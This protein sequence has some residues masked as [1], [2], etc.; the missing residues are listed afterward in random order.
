MPGPRGCHNL[1]MPAHDCTV[2]CD[3]CGLE[4][5][6]PP[7]HARLAVLLH[8]AMARCWVPIPPFTLPEETTS[9]Q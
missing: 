8:Q 9:D 4:L 6:A 1:L 7:E 5:E 2:V 3:L